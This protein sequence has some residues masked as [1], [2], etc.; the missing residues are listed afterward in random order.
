MLVVVLSMADSPPDSLEQH[1]ARWKGP[2][3]YGDGRL[4]PETFHDRKRFL[5][6]REYAPDSCQQ[7]VHTLSA[8]PPPVLYHY[9]SISAACGIIRS[10]AI[11]ATRMAFLDDIREMHYG[12]DLFQ[13]TF[14]NFV[15]QIPSIFQDTYS[16]GAARLALDFFSSQYVPKQEYPL[17]VVSFCSDG[18][19][20]SLWSEYG[21][22]A[23]G[24]ALGLDA[25]MMAR[26]ADREI[27]SFGSVVYDEGENISRIRNI[28]RIAIEN[29]LVALRDNRLHPSLSHEWFSRVLYHSI[30]PIL[31]LMKHPTFRDQREWRFIMLERAGR[32][33]SGRR[34]VDG[35]EVPYREFSV[36]SHVI[37]GLKY[38]PIVHVIRGPGATDEDMSA[39]ADVADQAGYSDLKVLR[40][41]CPLRP[42]GRK[43]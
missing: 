31:P 21:D 29:L 40:S 14:R 11:W 34:L 18:D 30:L 23:C 36:H 4:R 39:L 7:Y 33:V 38:L 13:S 24:V 22:R 17:Y 25:R 43:G 37:G 12:V 2:H 32:F 41:T 15:E 16:I 5:R 27:C 9:T 10:D 28:L 20:S 19:I 8:N 42:T 3:S 1:E 6:L 35:R 26:F